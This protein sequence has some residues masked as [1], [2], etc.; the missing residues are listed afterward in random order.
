MGLIFKFMEN[1]SIFEVRE[2][3]IDGLVENFAE[4]EGMNPEDVLSDIIT[5]ASYKGSDSSNPDYIEQVAEMMG[6]PL[7]EMNEYATNKAKKYVKTREI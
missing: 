2:A 7:D 3:A 1:G 4:K 5:F 6:I